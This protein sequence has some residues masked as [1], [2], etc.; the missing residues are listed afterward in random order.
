MGFTTFAVS[1][2]QHERCP[3]SYFRFVFFMVLVD[4]SIYRKRPIFLNEKCSCLVFL[5]NEV[6]CMSYIW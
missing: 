1:D 4:F 5:L 2:I 3:A 6:N